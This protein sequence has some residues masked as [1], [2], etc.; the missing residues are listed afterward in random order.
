MLITKA[1]LDRYRA[2]VDAYGDAAASYVEQY[3]RTLAEESH[4][5][6]VSELRDEAIKAIDEA[7]SAFGDQ[8]S[9]L[10]L[11]LFEEIVSDYG[12]EPE[13]R[14][15]DVIPHEMVDGGV[16]YLARALVEGMSDKFARDVADLSRYYIHRSAFE[17]MERN[18]ERNDLR[19]ARVPSGR[20]TCGFCFMLSSRGFVYRS[21]ETA[22]GTH[23]YH[24][25]CDCVIVPGFKGLPWD[26]QIEGY[27]PDAMR[28]R[29]REC[30]RA[31]GTNK[32]L[33]ERWKSMTGEQRSR[34]K[35]KSDAE[36]YRRFANAQAI[37]EAETRDFRW[38]NSGEHSGIEFTD[39][40][41]R[42]KKES[43]WKKDD[44]ERVTALKLNKLGY[45]A[46]FWDDELHVPNPGGRGTLTRGRPDLSTGVEIK[47]MYSMSSENTF[48][49]HMKSCR[50]K[51]GL[52]FVVIDVSENANVSRDDILRW[53]RKYMNRYK[54]DE[55]RIL[56]SDSELERV[57]L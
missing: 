37:G 13:T 52:K 11:D 4:G 53:T 1:R 27:D 39:D 15:D 19:Y 40:G 44:G 49:K 42:K 41:V 32:E 51:S 12:I 35:G 14:L 33:R 17:N 31:V 29:W 34:Y 45:R 7:L 55:T 36:C 3:V 54:I 47:T 50:D 56:W 5:A 8:A 20:E 43:A 10:A 2:G 57:T 18:C 28:G 38:L 6:P 48:K 21:E 25:H 23:A 30:Q 24:E 46:E 26:E 22:G 9:E 16:R